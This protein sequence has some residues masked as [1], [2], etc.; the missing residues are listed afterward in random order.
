MSRVVTVIPRVLITS[1]VNKGRSL[2]I[3]S[4]RKNKKL[5]LDSSTSKH[6]TPIKEQLINYKL[7]QN[8]FIL[9][10]NSYYISIE[11]IGDILVIINNIEILITKVNY[12][13]SLKAILL[14]FKELV[15]KG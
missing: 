7:V 14:S 1:L 10:A 12:V 8:K 13:P 11:G 9:V 3:N 6:Y 4:T 2:V 5:V 15:N